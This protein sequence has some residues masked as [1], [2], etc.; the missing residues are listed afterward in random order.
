MS[1]CEALDSMHKCGF[2]HNDVRWPNVIWEP[3]SN[4]YLVIDFESVRTLCNHEPSKK[5]NIIGH[6]CFYAKDEWEMVRSNL[7]C[8]RDLDISTDSYGEWFDSLLDNYQN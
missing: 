3:E 4:K 7:K 8:M 2:A 1:V 6:T 5:P